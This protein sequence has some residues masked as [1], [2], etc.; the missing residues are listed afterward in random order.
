MSASITELNERSQEI[1]RAV[2]LITEISEQTNLL[3]LNAAIEAARA[4]ESGRGFAVVADEVRKLAEKTRTA[5]QAIGEVMRAL[6]QDG[7]EMQTSAQQVS[8]L[9][10]DSSETVSRL[11]DT[12]G[13][14]SSSASE[15]GKQAVRVH[16][17]SFASLVKMDHMI[18]KQRTY[19]SLNTGGDRQY[20]DPVA[21]DHL[22]CRLGKWYQGEGKEVFGQ[23]TAYRRLEAPHAHVHSGAHRVVDALAQDWAN[24]A[25]AQM[26]LMAGINEMEEGSLEVMDLL[27]SM[28]AEKHPQ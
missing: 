14:F 8:A 26:S 18:Y 16:D 24:D 4:G 20:T 6:V 28:V 17:K 15:T 13:R 3:A 19:L 21:V 7:V 1:N 27:D 9:T 5:S 2:T 22:N 10:A 25:N 23:L 11:S 12:F